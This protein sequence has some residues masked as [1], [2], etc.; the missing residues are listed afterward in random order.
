MSVFVALVA[1]VLSA[2]VL[3]VAAY[4]AQSR[5]HLGW[6]VKADLQALF[7]LVRELFLFGVGLGVG[8]GFVVSRLSDDSLVLFSDVLLSYLSLVPFSMVFPL[9]LTYHASTLIFSLVL[10]NHQ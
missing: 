5:M 9:C 7:V 6:S 8:V 3:V 1:V 2:V 4:K 10:T